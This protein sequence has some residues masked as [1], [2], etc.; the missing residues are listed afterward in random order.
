MINSLFPI[1]SPDAVRDFEIL[2]EAK[3][4]TIEQTI[5]QNDIKSDTTFIASKIDSVALD[6]LLFKNM[7]HKDY[8]NEIFGTDNVYNE[9]RHRF[10]PIKKTDGTPRLTNVDPKTN[11]ISDISNPFNENFITNETYVPLTIDM[12][13]KAGDYKTWESQTWHSTTLDILSEMLYGY[14]VPENQRAKV[15]NQ[16][17]KIKIVNPKGEIIPIDTSRVRVEWKEGGDIKDI[18]Y[19]GKITKALAPNIKKRVQKTTDQNGKNTDREHIM[20]LEHDDTLVPFEDFKK[21]V[22]NYLISKALDDPVY[23]QK[24]MDTYSPATKIITNIVKGDTDTLFV[25][26]NKSPISI[27]AGYGMNVANGSKPVSEARVMLGYAFNNNYGIE[28][29]AFMTL[30]QNINSTKQVFPNNGY[31]EG[32][33]EE[34]FKRLSGFGGELGVYKRFKNFVVG[35]FG[36]IQSNTRNKTNTTY[37]RDFKNGLPDDAH[38]TRNEKN[39]TTLSYGGGLNVGVDL[40]DKLGFKLGVGYLNENKPS[41]DVPGWKNGSMNTSIDLKYNFGGGKP[42]HNRNNLPGGRRK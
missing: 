12:L 40:S 7:T 23:L 21:F 5:T 20:I 29:T 13:I 14:N 30:P 18:Y 25:K 39:S 41:F 27:G 32:S 1:G 4:H 24:L 31:F 8:L 38:I 33:R 16:I 28:G 36:R 19:T 6:N 2:Q 9:S 34:E 11:K 42:Y 35:L 22:R 17:K 3:K 37:E 15:N 26:V 10:V